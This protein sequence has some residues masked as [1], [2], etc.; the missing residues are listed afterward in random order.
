MAEVLGTASAVAGL[1][2]LSSKILAE[3][4]TYVASV[5]RAP[6][7]LRELLCESAAVDAVLSQLQGLS[8]EA[9]S[10][11]I[12]RTRLKELVNAG[13]IKECTE[14]LDMVRRS[15]TRCQQ[16]AGGT[17]ANFGKRTIWPFKE[18]E[19]KEAM[20]RLSRL[21]GHLTT[22]LTVDM[23]HVLHGVH[24]TSQEIAAGMF[25]VQHWMSRRDEHRDHRDL[26]KW[27]NPASIDVEQN[28]REG[29]KH[30][31]P[32]TGKW[33][34]ESESFKSWSNGPSS[35][36]WIHGIESLRQ[37]T[38]DQSNGL[39]Y[40]F[41]DHRDSNKRS[42]RHLLAI[43]MTQLLSQQ[44]ENQELALEVFRKY[45]RD[46]SKEV[47]ALDQLNLFGTIARRF[48]ALTIVVDAL[49]ECNDLA[50]FTKGI[51][52]LLSVS[53]TIVRVL[54]TGRSE[55]SLEVAVGSLA[56]HRITLE[57]NISSDI[58]VFVVDQVHSLIEAR[59]L[60]IRSLELKDI[61]IQTLSRQANGMFIWAAL[62]LDLISQLTNDKAIRD[63][64]EKLPRNL[65][66]SYTR[67][68]A[69]VKDR[70]IENLEIVRKALFWIAFTPVP[71][72]L[73]QLREAISIEPQD[74]YRDKDKMITDQ[75]DI[76]RMLGSLVTVDLTQEDPV[77]SL[78]HFTLYEFLQSESLRRHHYLSMFYISKRDESVLTE[79]CAHYLS[80]LDFE[81]PCGTVEELHN[82]ISSYKLLEYAARNV[83]IYM[84]VGRV[85]SLLTFMDWF[86]RPGR[87]SG[88]QFLSWQQVIQDEVDLRN[89]WIC[90]LAFAL[91]NRVQ[92]YAE[93]LIPA[94]L[95]AGADP[96]PLTK[97]GY[98][99]LHIA[100]I[101]GHAD[102]VTA[103]LHAGQ[104]LEAVTDRWH[105]A[106]H[107][108]A[109]YG[110]VDIVKLLLE[111]G[112]SPFAESD[113]GS[114][115]F[116]RAARIGS[117]PIMQL[118]HQAGSDVNAATWDHWTPIAEAVTNEHV[119]AV[120][121]LL[122]RGARVNCEVDSGPTILQ[123]ARST[124]NKEIIRLIE[125]AISMS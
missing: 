97:E 12:D 124:D 109:E 57:Q 88:Q 98:S 28:L 44:P 106:L 100:V 64:L 84:P 40:F 23:A 9:Q 27:L 114:T 51:S 94:L 123:L 55:Y 59:K 42:F 111:T 108:A 35:L 19:T 53:N 15:I 107:V 18:K 70:N 86:V 46:T 38:T 5:H 65:E 2:S 119:V 91:A 37:E 75:D 117:I 3:G 25:N 81:R 11:N 102:N 99:S 78:T 73:A 32:G 92:G 112:A 50:E 96:E 10:Q 77:V 125:N 103:A 122:N 56:T 47:T 85:A 87:N 45:G 63:A 118:P 93:H 17:V 89:L 6:R 68:L 21:R 62:Q 4:Y 61:I 110:H 79:L 54:A 22:A 104:G 71:L 41:Y 31:H 33:L 36:L 74:T 101:T 29:L 24:H 48:T 90:P 14:S 115:P 49:D 66:D 80:F 43:G 26:L 72:T 82:R 60:K 121:W 16:I 39:V 8:D 30:H 95:A 13:T 76:L 113:S 69:H 34:L 52:H 7:E 116:Y 105:T 120:E 1:T 83:Y 67:M 20:E 58:H